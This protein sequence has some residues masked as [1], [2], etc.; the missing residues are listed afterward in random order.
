MKITEPPPTDTE[1][2]TE[3]DNDDRCYSIPPNNMSGG[4]HVSRGT[5]G[6]T[7]ESEVSGLSGMSGGSAPPLPSPASAGAALVSPETLSRHSSPPPIPAHPLHQPA[8]SCSSHRVHMESPMRVSSPP[9]LSLGGSLSLQPVLFGPGAPTHAPLPPARRPSRPSANVQPVHVISAGDALA[10]T[11][12]ALYGKLL[13]VMGIAF[14]MA[15]V[16]STYIPPSFYEGFYL[17]LYI[18]SM[19]FLLYM[20]AALVRDRNRSAQDTTVATK[21]DSSSAISESGS[22]SSQ[23]ERSTVTTHV[24]PPQLM[25]K[26]MSLGF[27]LATTSGVRTHHYGSFYL[28]MGAVAFGI[29][30]MIYSGLEFGQYWELERNTNCHNVL[31]ALTPATRMAFI[32]IQMYFI[33]LNNEVS[34]NSLP[35]QQ[36][37]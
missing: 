36:S 4:S 26:R 15:E 21:S 25:T 5:F 10:T 23:T 8:P 11:L 1:G 18:G 29:G 6:G 3:T 31:L 7:A 24:P 12:S 27:A 22:C 28:R 20:Y 35:F 34:I 9:S 14:P 37:V 32:F 2:G 16:I 33:F 19:V 17:Y 30:S 13:V